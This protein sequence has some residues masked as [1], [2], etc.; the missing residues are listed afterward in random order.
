MRAYVFCVTSYAIHVHI[1]WYVLCVFLMILPDQFE[2]FLLVSTS[3][4]TSHCTIV[5]FPETDT[6]SMLMLCYS[7]QSQTTNFAGKYTTELYV[8]TVIPDNIIS[9]ATTAA[10]GPHLV[11]RQAV[12]AGRKVTVR[13]QILLKHQ[14]DFRF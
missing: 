13:T 14:N 4:L 5:F 1:I 8:Y 12:A 11:F 2:D 3:S 7:T 10:T 9:A 6:N